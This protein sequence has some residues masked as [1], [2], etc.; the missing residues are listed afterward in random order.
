MARPD[1][2][3]AQAHGSDG[4]TRV[5]HLLA[6]IVDQ[7]AIANWQRSKDGRKNRNRPK[8]ISPLNRTGTR[9]GKTDRDPDEVA[10]FLASI[11]PPTGG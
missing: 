4:W 6:L 11:G 7:L 8:P 10:A 2:L 1:S 3:T 9:F 5:E